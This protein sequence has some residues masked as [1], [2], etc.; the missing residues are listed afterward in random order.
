MWLNG[1][2]GHV[3][4]GRRP[5]GP[6]PVTA[7][8]LVDYDGS[9]EHAIRAL[10]AWVEDG[11]G[12]PADTRFR[13]EDGRFTLP[14]TAN[15]RL[16]IQPVVAA[17]AN[18]ETATS[19]R[20]GEPVRLTVTAEAPPDAGSIVGAEWDFDG[21]GGWPYRHEIPP[22]GARALL[23]ATVERAF[24]RPGTYYPAVRVASHAGGDV[25]ARDGRVL[26]LARVRVD[27]AS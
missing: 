27:V 18:G 6:P 12:P 1:N 4:P 17:S 13:Y 16:G 22:G 8:R 11:V 23:E 14:E 19:A 3:D 10:I 20:V 7:T 24:E 15:E 2:A 21:T 25:A 5:A 9:V 26:N